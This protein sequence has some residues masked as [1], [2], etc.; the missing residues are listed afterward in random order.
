MN[1]RDTEA[2]ICIMLVIL[3]RWPSFI[4]F[5]SIKAIVRHYSDTIVNFEPI[6]GTLIQCTSRFTTL[7]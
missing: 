7:S 1:R 2:V 4:I 5:N 6:Q 3:C